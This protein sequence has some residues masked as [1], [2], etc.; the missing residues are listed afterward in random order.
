MPDRI[1][2]MNDVPPPELPEL[3]GELPAALT[4]EERRTL[5]ESKRVFPIWGLWGLGIAAFALL[6]SLGIRGVSQRGESI[7]QVRAAASRYE[8][9][10][11]RIRGRVGEVFEMG[12]SHVYYL[13]QGRDTL[14]VFT[15]GAAPRSG[16]V[17]TVEGTLSVG[18]LDGTARP[19]LFATGP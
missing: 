16:E 7:S 18:Y 10:T 5:A 12:V 13:H 8:G 9:R 6:V 1:D 4:A 15:R 2:P 14:V 3:D 17:I 11:L 19:A